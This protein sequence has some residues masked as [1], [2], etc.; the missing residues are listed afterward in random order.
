MWR[1]IVKEKWN[2]HKGKRVF[3]GAKQGA[4]GEYPRNARSRCT[5]I[6]SNN[7]SQIFIQGIKRVFYL[8]ELPTLLSFLVLVLVQLKSQASKADGAFL[9][10]RLYQLSRTV[11]WSWRNLLP[12]PHSG[13]DP[14]LG[15]GQCSFVGEDD[16]NSA[17]SLNGT[18]EATL[19]L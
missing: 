8:L 11:I 16:E 4:P 12:P 7:S 13:W 3:R 1:N 18:N 2:K 10:N 5:G 19:D 15:T 9:G 6:I 17:Y 14:V